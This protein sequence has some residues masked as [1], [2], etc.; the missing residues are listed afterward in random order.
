MWLRRLAGGTGLL[1]VGLACGSTSSS[2]PSGSTSGTASGSGGGSTNGGSVTATGTG[3]V[4][5]GGTA[6]N[7]STSAGGNV[8]AGGGTGVGG[9]AGNGNGGAAGE[10]GSTSS[11]G[12]GGGGG[13]TGGAPSDCSLPYSGPIGGPRTD[14]PALIVTPCDQISDEV[15]LGRYAD[16]S[17]KVPQGLYWEPPGIVSWWE[18]PCSDSPDETLERSM[19]R[20]LG[21]VE[22]QASS[23]WSHEVSGC[24][25]GSRR[26][27][28]N[29][30]CDYYD[31]EMLAGGAFESLAYLAS[32]LWW[33]DH[34]NLQGSQIL[35]YTGSIGDATDQVI[36]CTIRTT[37][38]DFGLC[39]Q[40]TLEQATHRVVVNGQVQLGEPSVVRT[41]EG[42]CH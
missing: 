18:S 11:G 17:N 10:G 24:F 15:I 40:I 14:G 16:A 4:G 31:G 9:S 13:G 20:P 5:S 21:D 25:E 42:T 27:Y 30:R 32:L 23:D 37:F 12:S 29:L 39:D 28:S 33:M 1:L 19:E 22:G 7:G 8:G 35:G 2:D 3:T 36:M 38:G 41:I 26:V 6:S 34:G